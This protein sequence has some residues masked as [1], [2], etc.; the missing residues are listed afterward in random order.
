MTMV[1]ASYALAWGVALSVVLG[2]MVVGLLW[3]NAEI[4]LNDYP[5]DVRA[6]YGAISERS[7]RQR[8]VVSLVFVLVI[9]AF[10]ALSCRSLPVAVPDDRSFLEVF[11]HLAVMFMVF[12]VVDL[13]LIDVP[14]VWLQPAFA[15]LPGTEGLAGYRD[16]GFHVRGFFKGTAGILVLSVTLAAGIAAAF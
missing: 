4:M 6:R 14:L 3:W 11:V 2:I 5:P 9:V 12:N 10:V 8:V 16:V 13:V 1:I 7:R 15:I